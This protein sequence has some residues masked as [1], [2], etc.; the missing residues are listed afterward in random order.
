MQFSWW[1][2]ASAAAILAS[3]AT[4]IPQPALARNIVGFSGTYAPG[5]GE[6]Q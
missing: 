2:A 6:N 3:S 4:A 5:G 1:L